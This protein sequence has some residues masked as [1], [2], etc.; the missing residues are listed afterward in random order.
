MSNAWQDKNVF[1]EGVTPFVLKAGLKK[2][3]KNDTAFLLSSV[4]LL[5]VGA[6]TAN[7]VKAAPVVYGKKNLPFDNIRLFI[8]NSGI[9]NALT[10][11]EGYADMLEVMQKCSAKFDISSESVIMS[12]TGVIGKRLPVSK[13]SDALSKFSAELATN[14][15]AAQA[16]MTTDTK[17]KLGNR[18]FQINGET[19]EISY[20]AKGSGMISPNVATML[21]FIG[22]NVR[23]TADELKSDL[24]YALNKSINN[25]TVDGDMSTNDS[26]FLFSNNLGPK[27]SNAQALTVWRENLQDVCYEIAEK[28]VR[29]GEGATKFIR[30][31]V[32]KAESEQDAKKAA[33]AVANSALVKTAMFGEDPNIGRIAAAVG[34]SGAAFE[35]NKLN[36][37]INKVKVIKKGLPTAE[38]AQDLLS[39]N[40]I[41]IKIE[42]NSG[43]SSAFILTTDLSYDYV[44]INAE[45][46]T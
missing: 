15:S 11:A 30:I 9:A 19:A 22:T 8:I 42:L 43:E 39:A 3:G 21:V 35:E 4:P 18:T 40:D 29:D 24:L 14:L 7:R 1:I 37:A 17:P 28:I 12:S 25:I 34:Y 16:I 2:S 33:L 44:K 46:H 13:I 45:Y 5:T 10:G 36:V 41:N 27:I 26:V 6:F 31:D 32:A 23:R 38:I 20:I